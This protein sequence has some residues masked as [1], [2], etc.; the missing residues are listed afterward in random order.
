MYP[1][2]KLKGQRGRLKAPLR[3]RSFPRGFAAREFGLQ[4]TPKI[5][6]AR[7][8]TSGTQGNTLSNTNVT[9]IS[10]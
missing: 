8:K 3:A 10:L 5:P 7:E 9:S 4:P 6:A 1:I 2:K